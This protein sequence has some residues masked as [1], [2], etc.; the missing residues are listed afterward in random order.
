MRTFVAIDLPENVRATIRHQQ[1]LFRAACAR[2]QGH[3]REIRWARPEGIHLTLKFLGE[4]STQQF[5][6]VQEALNSLGPFQ[7][8][9]V[10]IKGFGFFPDARRP[11]VFWVGVGAPP[12][13]EQ[14]AGRVEAAMEA[15]GFAR[16]S[17]AYRPH[18]TLA[19]FQAP[20]PQPALEALIKEEGEALLGSFLVSECFLFESKLLPRGAEYVKLARFPL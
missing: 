8:F 9:E 2:Q 13:L 14:F 6:E 16:E 19:R 7:T 1:E 18:L 12:D 3:G 15:L 20:H 17:R 11:R 5:R 10:H 4:I